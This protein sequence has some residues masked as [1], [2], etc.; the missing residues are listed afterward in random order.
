MTQERAS[1]AH[2]PLQTIRYQVAD[3]VG[4][5]MELWGFKRIMGRT[6]TLLYLADAPLSAAELGDALQVSPGSVSMT[7]SELLKWGV[8]KKT[9]VPGDRRDFYLPETSVWKMVSR[10]IRERELLYVRETND[11]LVAAQGLLSELQGSGAPDSPR[12]GGEA[13]AGTAGEAQSPPSSAAL[14]TLSSRITAL[15]QLSQVGQL[16]IEQALS[17]RTID[18]V[19]LQAALNLVA[20]A[21]PP[22]TA[23]GAPAEPSPAPSK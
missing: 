6:W 12:E 8:V 14:H 13:P 3:A 7:V 16:L 17:G 2:D 22:P 4:G 11:R 19:A 20:P 23:D 18:V 21:E 10:V 5:L 1:K 9:W 15:Q